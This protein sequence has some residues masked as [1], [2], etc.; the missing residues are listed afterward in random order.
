MWVAVPEKTAW[1]LVDHGGFWLAYR[2]PGD[3]LIRASK[4]GLSGPFRLAFLDGRGRL[5]HENAIRG[6]VAG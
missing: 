1:M 4:P 2:I 6:V 5:I 3:R